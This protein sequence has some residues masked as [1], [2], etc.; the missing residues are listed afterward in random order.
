MFSFRVDGVMRTM[1]TEKLLKTIPIIQNQMDA[2]LDF[3][4]SLAQYWVAYSVLDLPPEVFTVHTACTVFHQVL[5]WKDLLF[6]SK[7][8]CEENQIIVLCPGQC[9]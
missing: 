1:N 8:F 4:V 9:Q 6:S 3:N 5:F 7:S 2:L